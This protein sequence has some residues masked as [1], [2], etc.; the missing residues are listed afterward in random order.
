M[1]KEERYNKGAE[2]GL[3]KQYK[4]GARLCG[5]Y[6]KSG[7]NVRTYLEA[8]DIVKALNSD[9]LDLIECIFR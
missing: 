4:T 3:S 6:C 1:V 5:I 9:I 8:D 2:G 7:H